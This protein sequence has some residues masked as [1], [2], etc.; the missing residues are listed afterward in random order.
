MKYSQTQSNFIGNIHNSKQVRIHGLARH[1]VKR[2]DCTAPHHRFRTT[3]GRIED[4]HRPVVVGRPLLGRTLCSEDSAGK[5]SCVTAVCGSGKLECAGNVAV[6]PATFAEFTLDDGGG[7]DFY[8][9]SLVDGYNLPMLVVPQ[10]G[11]GANCSITGCCGGPQRRMPVGAH[12]DER[13]RRAGGLQERMRGVPEA[14][15]CPRAYSYAFDYKSSTFTCAGAD[16]HITFCPPPGT[17]QKSSSLEGHNP[18]SSNL[19]ADSTMVY[20]GALVDGLPPQYVREGDCG[21]ISPCCPALDQNVQSVPRTELP[22]AFATIFWVM[23][24]LA[25]MMRNSSVFLQVLS[26]RWLRYCLDLGYA[27]VEVDLEAGFAEIDNGNRTT[28]GEH[29]GGNDSNLRIRPVTGA[30]GC[31]ASVSQDATISLTE[32][33]T[34]SVC[35]ANQEVV[36]LSHK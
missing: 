21:A 36:S 23:M 31:L 22:A 17:S 15:A 32:V 11:T 18:M 14:R 25:S 12:G 7:L 34:I 3:E 27:R 20:E 29:N 33:S 26:W 9:V 13:R 19:P 2:R 35:S 16:Y 30:Y 28:R 8:D 10:R 6:P 5:S 1:F 24:Q 4:H